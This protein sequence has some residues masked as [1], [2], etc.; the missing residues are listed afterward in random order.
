MNDA[1]HV[2]KKDERITYLGNMIPQ[3]YLRPRKEGASEFPAGL[4]DVKH[5]HNLA[6]VAII[7]WG[8]TKTG[9]TSH[10]EIGGKRYDVE[11]LGAG[12]FVVRY[13]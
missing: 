5:F 8:Q 9:A 10:F 2:R 12:Q 7:Q 4:K 6:S 11:S 1:R 13:D 3:V